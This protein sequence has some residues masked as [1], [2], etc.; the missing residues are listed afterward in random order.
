[1]KWSTVHHKRISKS[2][3]NQIKV[4]SGGFDVLLANDWLI[5]YMKGLA[6]LTDIFDNFAEN[7]KTW[8]YQLSIFCN[9]CCDRVIRKRKSAVKNRAIRI[10]YSIPR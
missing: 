5:F 6:I 3:V 1:M 7:S 2:A 8:F 9:G 10:S 4:F